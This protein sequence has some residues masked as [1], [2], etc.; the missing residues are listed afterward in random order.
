MSRASGRVVFIH[1]SRELYG[2]DRMLLEVIATMPPSLTPL[3]WLPDDVPPGGLHEALAARGIATDT[4]PLPI[5]RR[6]YL[7]PSG[8]FRLLPRTLSLFHAI[9]RER[10]AAVYLT[11]SATLLAAPVVRVAGVRRVVLH[12]Q[13]LWAGA[14]GRVLGL[15][16]RSVTTAIA[17]SGPVASSL[18]DALAR[19]T[20]VVTNAVPDSPRARS[21]PPSTRTGDP[22]RFL[23]ASRWN[24][25]KGHATLLRA[26]DLGD[27]P[28]SLTVLGGPPPIGEATDVR[29]LVASSPNRDSIAIVGELTD[30]GEAIDGVDIVLVPSDQ[31]EPFGLVAIEA[32]SRGR[33]V[34]GSAGGGLAEIVLDGKTGR[35]FPPGDADALRKVLDEITPE[36]AADWGVAARDRYEAE[37]SLPRFGERMQRLWSAIAR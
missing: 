9:R 12:V 26:W 14:E 10:P 29:A 16:A 30:I 19:R 5:V 2:A 18:P 6:R 15:L 11:T 27:A 32:Y 36:R 28:G 7:T 25:W 35:L 37:Y 17:I 13:E 3:V 22:L 34:V 23:V 4:H 31:P 33:A 24:A 21:T 1:S 20:H 8:L